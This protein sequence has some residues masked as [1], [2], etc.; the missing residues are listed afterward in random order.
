MSRTST[1]SAV[2]GRSGRGRRAVAVLLGAAAVAALTTITA[3]AAVA[4]PE[5]PGG[6]WDHIYSA[7]G[8]R[9]YVVEHG[10]YISVCDTAANGHG[11]VVQVR[12][13]TIWP[14]DYQM[15]AL[16]GNGTCSSHRASDGARYDLDEV[17]IDLEFD[18]DG[19][20]WGGSGYFLNDR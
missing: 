17:G 7:P 9:V 6:S 20:E 2:T 12:A 11:A 19:G 14:Y 8:V 1:S 16:A 4:A 3:P 18:G 15:T 5:P 13:T 10:D